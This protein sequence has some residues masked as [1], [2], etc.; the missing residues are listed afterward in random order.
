MR[1]RDKLLATGVLAAL[2]VGVF[3]WNV[4]AQTAT[5][6]STPAAA[7]C[8]IAGLAPDQL[9]TIVAE[10]TPGAV[11]TPE[12][13]GE[14]VPADVQSA[15]VATVSGSIACVNANS[16]LQAYAFFTDRYLQN[17]FSGSGADDLGHLLVAITRNPGTA[18][19]EDRLALISIDK[20]QSGGDGS[21]TA[22]VTTQNADG[23]Y[24]DRLVFVIANGTWLIDADY[25]QSSPATPTA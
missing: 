11:S 4:N 25:P 12:V 17:R 1:I 23:T 22:V 14:S 13:S 2:T 10:G 3:H 21:V 8:T 9:S 5:L 15:I 16:P 20:F 7:D 6:P 18:T 24:V 19:P